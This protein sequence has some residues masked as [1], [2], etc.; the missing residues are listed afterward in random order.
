VSPAVHHDVSPPLRDLV[1]TNVEQRGQQQDLPRHALSHQTTSTGSA[2]DPVAQTSPV[3]P[4]TAPT[5]GVNLD[6]IGVG[7]GSYTDCCAPPDPN[8]AVGPN[9]FVEMVNVDIAVFSKAGGLLLGPE[10]SNTLWS[11]FG[12]VRDAQRRRRLG[13]LRPDRRSLGDQ[14]VRRQHESES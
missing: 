5:I 7:F 8:G 11:G 10:R 3:A 12:G 13:P 6:G 2:P 1:P 4:L 14:P 9:H